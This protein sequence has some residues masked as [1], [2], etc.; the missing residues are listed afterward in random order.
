MGDISERASQ[1]LVSLISGDAV[2]KR[3]EFPWTV[4]PFNWVIPFEIQDILTLYNFIPLAITS[5]FWFPIELTYLF[6]MFIPI[7]SLYPVYYTIV[8]ITVPVQV[9]W[10]SFMLLFEFAMLNPITGWIPFC[11]YWFLWVAGVS[12]LIDL[13]ISPEAYG[14]VAWE[15]DETNVYDRQEDL[16]II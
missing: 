2:S 3:V 12:F 4:F 6:F 10:H 1:F 15:I 7:Y 5:P 13:I 16:R 8:T 11:L 9:V 14:L